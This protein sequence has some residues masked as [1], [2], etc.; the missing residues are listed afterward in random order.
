M[1]DPDPGG[2]ASIPSATGSRHGLESHA[3]CYDRRLSLPH[4]WVFFVS[5]REMP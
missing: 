5:G 3:L 2:N 4:P 1:P